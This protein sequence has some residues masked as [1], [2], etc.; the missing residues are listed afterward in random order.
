MTPLK[1]EV[2]KAPR[3]YG[4]ALKHNQPKGFMGTTGSVFGWYRYKSDAIKRAGELT[5]QH[6]SFVV[7]FSGRF[8]SIPD[9]IK[10]L[11]I[12]AADIKENETDALFNVVDQKEYR[13]KYSLESIYHDP[14]KNTQP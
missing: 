1:I 7:N 11:K 9:V 13:Y 14:A 2:V 5:R 3:G 10:A 12:M 8:N 4:Y 6:V